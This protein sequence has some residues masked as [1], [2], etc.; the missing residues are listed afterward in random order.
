MKKKIRTDIVIICSIVLLFSIGVILF[1]N[2][3][4]GN[5]KINQQ[6]TRFF[7]TLILVVFTVLNKDWAK[8]ILSVLLILGG[9]LGLLSS[10]KILSIS[11]TAGI[12]IIVMGVFYSFAGLYIIA[13][14]NKWKRC[15]APKYYLIDTL[16]DRWSIINW[17]KAKIFTGIFLIR[18]N[19][20]LLTIN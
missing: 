19:D 16:I 10:I 2:Q 20:D 13:T 12:F 18:K 8:W 7:L 11:A 5:E 14:R 6:L 17:P 1:Y 4:I 3:T 9:I 15:K